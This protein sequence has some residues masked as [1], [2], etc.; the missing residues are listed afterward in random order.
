MIIYMSLES[1]ANELREEGFPKQATLLES[2][3]GELYLYLLANRNT[4]VTNNTLGKDLFA[5]IVS[6][7]NDGE[8]D[9]EISGNFLDFEPRVYSQPQLQVTVEHRLT[10]QDIEKAAEIERE[11]A[12]LRVFADGEIYSE[13]K[14][15]DD[16][17]LFEVYKDALR[18]NK[19][20][21][22]K[23]ARYFI[24]GRI[25]RLQNLID[26]NAPEQIL[27]NDYRNVDEFVKRGYDESKTFLQNCDEI[28]VKAN[29][30]LDLSDREL[31]KY[32]LEL[33]NNVERGEVLRYAN[34]LL[35][36]LEPK[37][38]NIIF[39]QDLNEFSEEKSCTPEELMKLS[40]GD[41]KELVLDF[42]SN[43][44]NIRHFM[45]GLQQIV[46]GGPVTNPNVSEV[47]ILQNHFNLPNIRYSE[48]SKQKLKEVISDTR[49]LLDELPD[50]SDL[51]S[52][53]R[54]RKKMN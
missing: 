24:E 11:L 12:E 38:H 14:N 52:P 7:W 36:S 31:E 40:L 16:D 39:Y 9:L 45:V 17:L 27:Q 47:S 46:A 49:N 22:S 48:E 34:R 53:S 8:Y 1:I 15:L 13:L 10:S 21:T 43:L 37:D 32:C 23:K 4:D 29:D 51:A 54:L 25:E 44:S 42:N 33:A 6:E 28:I 3:R 18:L 2:G 41:R 19:V 20:S 5:K 50:L 26:L 30:L 35:N